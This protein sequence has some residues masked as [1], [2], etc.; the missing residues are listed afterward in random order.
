VISANRYYGIADHYSPSVPA[1]LIQGNYIGTDASGTQPLGN[2]SD[3]I[4]VGDVND[5]IGGTTAGAGNVISANGGSGISVDYGAGYALVQGN[6]IGTDKTGTKPLGNTL[7]GVTAVY[8]ANTIGGTAAGAG[9]VIAA[10]GG[11]GIVL[12]GV[13]AIA[14]LIQGNFIG[15]DTTGAKNLG[16]A[17]HGVDVQVYGNSIGGTVRGAGNTIAFNGEAGVAVVDN[18]NEVPILS[19]AIYAN[20]RL[21]ID[22]NDD[23]VTLNHLG[24]PISGPNNFQ[25]FPVLTGA[26]GAGGTTTITGSLNGALG[27][28]YLIQFF[29]NASADPTGYGQGQA[30][31]GSI[32]VMTDS[33]GNASFTA[34][35]K[36]AVPA[37]QFVSAAATD[38]SGDTSE[39]SQDVVVTKGGSAPLAV[40]SVGS[41]LSIAPLSK[42]STSMLAPAP[43]P[44][45]AVVDAAVEALVWDEVLIRPRRRTV[46]DGN[47]DRSPLT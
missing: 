37:G 7:G 18:A 20:H 41:R 46:L 45:G 43:V 33:S 40:V 1:T 25:N 29:A 30:L 24:G 23:G 2:G 27:T 38:P 10:N 21:G 35:F 42:E 4:N 6:L 12:G 39:F 36:G 28:S 44:A 13:Y 15:T 32:T 19:N 8:F 34:T 26:V 17:G 22:L 47:E 16:N 3:G 31:I 14:N 11:D 9:N 5:T